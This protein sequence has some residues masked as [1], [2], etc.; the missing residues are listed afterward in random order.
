MT[1]TMPPEPSCRQGD[2]VLV[3]FPDSNLRTGKVR[4]VLIVQADGLETGLPQVVVAMITS[5]L[6]RAGHAS[7]V[8]ISRATSTGR[9]AGLLSD[10]IVMTDNLATVSQ[11]EIHRVIG[12]LPMGE[13]AAALRHTLGL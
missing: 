10:S 3:F 2:V 1:T 4:P 5:N 11:S 9:Q 12:S 7:R 13:V 8:Q 6:S